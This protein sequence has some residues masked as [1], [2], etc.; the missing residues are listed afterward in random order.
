MK[1]RDMVTALRKLIKRWFW[2]RLVNPL[3]PKIHIQ[4]LNIDIHTKHFHLGDQSTYWKVI[5]KKWGKGEN[6]NI[7]IL[8][9]VKIKPLTKE[10]HIIQGKHDK[11]TDLMFQASV[12]SLCLFSDNYHIYIFMSNKYKKFC[13]EKTAIILSLTR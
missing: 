8:F 3:T 10:H 12:F 13:I 4:I 1:Y 5:F 7:N 11:I 6:V 9:H 2:P